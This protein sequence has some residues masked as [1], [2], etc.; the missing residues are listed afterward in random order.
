DR[1]MGALGFAAENCHAFQHAHVLQLLA[2][3]KAKHAA[4]LPLLRQLVAGLA[5]WFPQ[6]AQMMDAAL[7][8]TMAEQGFDATRGETERPRGANAAPITGCGSVSCSD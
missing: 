7:A 4:N 2:E 6:H 3:V 8:Q 1:W 5:E